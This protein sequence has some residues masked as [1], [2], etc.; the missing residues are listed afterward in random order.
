MGKEFQ[1]AYRKCLRT[2]AL[3]KGI[4]NVRETI[5]K[6]IDDFK[7]EEAE[8]SSFRKIAG[9]KVTVSGNQGFFP[10]ES[11]S[12]LCQKYNLI[13]LRESFLKAGFVTPPLLAM[14][15]ISKIASEINS[16]N[17]PE[18]EKVIKKYGPLMYSTR[19][20]ASLYE[21]IYSVNPILA[22]YSKQI[23]ECIEAFQFGL[24]GVA[25]T[26]LMPCI[27]GIIRDIGMRLGISCEEHIS[28]NQ[29]IEIVE[30]LQKRDIKEL[31]FYG[32]LW[33]PVDFLSIELHDHF[34]E[35]I[36]F[37]QSL[38]FYLKNS[39][40]MHTQE[41]DGATG[42]NR[43][44]VLHG[45]ITNFHSAENFY[46]L[47]TVVNLLYVCALIAGGSGS[48]FH[49]NIPESPTEFEKRLLSIAVLRVSLE[50]NA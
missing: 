5:S 35:R 20:L 17:D 31:V 6:C 26:G 14:G 42:L 22:T 27:E 30:R 36:Q 24:F 21:N 23:R 19:S 3:K 10:K 45:F 48:M 1:V 11:V 18:I 39:L 40:Y 8:V 2:G 43:N 9:Y 49:P 4:D 25:I 44:G 16:T 13:W 50:K 34:N 37:V 7:V 38:K 47:I 33:V 32:Y 28:I 12:E 46:R 41:F 29:F 15:F